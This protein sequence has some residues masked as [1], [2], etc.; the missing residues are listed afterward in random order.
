M[1]KLHQAA[2]EAALQPCDRGADDFLPLVDL[3]ELV[4]HQIVELAEVGAPDGVPHGDEHVGSG[5]DEHALVDGNID[6]PFVLGLVGQ[7][8]GRD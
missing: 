5:L 3:E 8:A 4:L 7:D 1:L 6:R 2:D